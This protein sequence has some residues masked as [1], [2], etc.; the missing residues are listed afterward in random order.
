MTGS[1]RNPFPKLGGLDQI[2]LKELV[3]VA[4]SCYER[5]WSHG[6]AGNFSLRASDGIIWQSPSG[7]N[8][9]ALNPEFFIPVDLITGQAI[10]PQSP[11]PSLEMPVHLGIFRTVAAARTV[12]HTHPPALVRLSAPG[13]TLAFQ[14]QEMQKALGAADHVS[15]LE[16]PVIP[17]PTVA[18]MAGLADTV[19]A[20]L[21]LQ[22][23]MIVLA[24]H[25]V[26]AWGKSPQE[27][28]AY[29][30]AAEYICKISLTD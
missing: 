5:G 9:G 22:V 24:G 18:Q 29:I 23:P 12:V 1:T 25:G 2:L 10:S 21:N 11:T 8:K 27:A 4:R 30:E 13:M 7:L 15:R 3:G 28:L 20:S 16:I 17:N 26:Y 14:G 6:T 19:G